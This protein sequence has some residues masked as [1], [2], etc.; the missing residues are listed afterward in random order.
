MR[1]FGTAFE[2]T[3]TDKPEA[4]AAFGTVAGAAV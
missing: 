2:E 1:I 3:E 4:G